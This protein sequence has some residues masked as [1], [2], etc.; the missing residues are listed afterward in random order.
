[1]ILKWY[2]KYEN[3][4]INYLWFYLNKLVKDEKLHPKQAR[5]REY[6]NWMKSIKYNVDK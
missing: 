2:K 1:M 5:H 4:K 3:F 6:V